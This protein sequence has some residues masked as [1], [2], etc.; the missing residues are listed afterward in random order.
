MKVR[1]KIPEFT[2]HD[3]KG[4]HTVA[5]VGEVPADHPAIKAALVAGYLVRDMT[6]TSDVSDR[7]PS[8]PRKSTKK[9][10]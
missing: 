4:Y 10:A 6:E 3:A 8:E 2:W 7:V 1:V 9:E 5:H